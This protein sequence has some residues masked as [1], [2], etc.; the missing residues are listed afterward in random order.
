MKTKNIL[1]WTIDATPKEY[2]RRSQS[3]ARIPLFQKSRWRCFNRRRIVDHRRFGQ[4]N[5]SNRLKKPIQFALDGIK[6]C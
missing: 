1:S 5:S 2:V 6:G 4:Q 3:K